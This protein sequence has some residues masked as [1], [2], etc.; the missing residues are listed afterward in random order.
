MRPRRAEGERGRR[1]EGEK[2][3]E[4][5]RGEEKRR[6]EKRFRISPLPLVTVY[7][8]RHF[9]ARTRAGSLC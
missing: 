2:R 9:L 3:R 8:T 1:R 5:K 4:E 6:E 7:D